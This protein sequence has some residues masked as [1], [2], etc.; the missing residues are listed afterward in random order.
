MAARTAKPIVKVE[1]AK[2]GIEIVA[3]HQNHHPAT[4]PDA[5]GVSG[6]AVDGLRRFDEFVGFALTFLGRIGRRGRI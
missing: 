3:P 5:F 1:M 2:R 6:R 4:K